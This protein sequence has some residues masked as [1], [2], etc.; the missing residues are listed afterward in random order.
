MMRCLLALGLVGCT[1]EAEFPINPELQLAVGEQAWILERDGSLACLGRFCDPDYTDP[2]E[3][4]FVAIDSARGNTCAID[5]EG[6]LWCWSKLDNLPP[7]PASGVYVDVAVSSNSG[8]ALRDDGEV[9][10]WSNDERL[11]EGVPPGPWVELELGYSPTACA[12]DAQGRAE[13]WGYHSS[14]EIPD[15]RFTVVDLSDFAAGLTPEGRPRCWGVDYCPAR[16]PAGA[17]IDLAFGAA[18]ECALWES[19]EIA[20]FTGD[21]DVWEPPSGEYTSVSVGTESACA[22]STKGEVVCWGEEL[23]GVVEWD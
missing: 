12:L 4:P 20:C 9:E 22:L 19:Q 15:E 1:A 21:V 14:W 3:G 16:M 6:A 17:L 7:P 13:C 10:C 23:W 8:C 11:V 18:T 5:P 2:P